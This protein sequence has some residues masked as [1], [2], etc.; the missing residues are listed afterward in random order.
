MCTFILVDMVTVFFFNIFSEKVLNEG[1]V[2]LNYAGIFSTV[3]SVF[4][5]RITD[6]SNIIISLF[7]NCRIV[8]VV[9]DFVYSPSQQKRLITSHLHLSQ[10]RVKTLHNILYSHL[11]Y[12]YLNFFFYIKVQR[13]EELK[14]FGKLVKPSAISRV[15]GN[16]DDSIGER[17]MA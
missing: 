17:A 8:H 6:Y 7:I 10:S 3:C 2:I 12:R 5:S 4:P 13:N 14:W 9:L 1:I 15:S 11:N 16:L